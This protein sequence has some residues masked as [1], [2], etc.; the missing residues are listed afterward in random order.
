M[1]PAY[2]RPPVRCAARALG[3]D[4]PGCL[5]YAVRADTRQHANTHSAAPPAQ[6]ASQ[7]RRLGRSKRDPPMNP[8]QQVTEHAQAGA[9]AREGGDGERVGGRSPRARDAGGGEVHGAGLRGP[10]RLRRA[11]PAEAMAAAQIKSPHVA[12]V[13]DHG[14]D[15]GRGAVHRDGAARGRGPQGPHAA[16]G[17]LPPVEVGDDRVAGGQGARPGAPGRDRP[18]RHQ[19]GQHL[20]ARRRGRAV[21]EGAR[22]RG[23]PSG[24]RASSA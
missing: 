12:Q 3:G 7:G 15:A 16:A 24:S 11:L 8:G 1:V 2:P 10:E 17:P 14:V 18:P 4:G 13:F 23:A 20:P 19:A 22:L 5:L 6:D 21:R 9:R